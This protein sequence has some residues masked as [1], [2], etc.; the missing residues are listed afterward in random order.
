MTNTQKVINKEF[1]D[2]EQAL[3]RAAQT[4]KKLAKQTGTP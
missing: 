4:A 1:N 2:I 3:R